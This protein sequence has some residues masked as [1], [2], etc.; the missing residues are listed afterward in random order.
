MKFY[1][2]K[3]FF[4]ALLLTTSN[5]ANAG[6]IIDIFESGN[7]I[8]LLGS[9]SF[10]T[11][12]SSVVGSS[13]FSGGFITGGS[14]ASVGSGTWD[15]YNGIISSDGLFGTGTSFAPGSAFTGSV[16]GIDL[17]QQNGLVFL[18]T[19]YFSGTALSGS[20]TITGQSFLSLGLVTGS[21]TYSTSTDSVT[22]NIQKVSSPSML[23]FFVITLG[24][25]L[26]R[27]IRKD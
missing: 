23:A 2:I 12:G 10:N 21:Y 5:L 17:L 1:S 26:L 9:G 8:I 6:L 16:F 20:T 19:N 11:S 7:D 13:S 22:I 18:P 27:T 24:I 15:A 4:I 25:F 3:C 14:V